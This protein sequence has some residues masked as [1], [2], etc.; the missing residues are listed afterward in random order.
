MR[1]PSASLLFVPPVRIPGQRLRTEHPEVFELIPVCRPSAQNLVFCFLQ[2][3]LDLSFAKI[4]SALKSRNSL[5][6]SAKIL[7]R[8]TAAPRA[9]V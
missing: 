9:Y 2:P 6:P 4:L 3:R 7:P 1:L 5:S 8:T